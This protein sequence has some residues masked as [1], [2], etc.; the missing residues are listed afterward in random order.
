MNPAM[1]V[2]L[3]S[4]VG[5]ILVVGIVLYRYDLLGSKEKPIESPTA[6]MK[7]P[8]ESV[9]SAPET[10]PAAAPAESSVPPENLVL[11]KKLYEEKTCV[12]CHGADGKAQTPTGVAMKATDLSSGQFHNNKTNMESVAYIKQVIEAGVPGTAMVGFQ[13]QIPDEKDRSALA[14]YVHSLSKKK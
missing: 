10:K 12:L 5:A 4:V 6:A 14:Q 13:A 7:A 3:G 1:R 9:A 2:L 8:A 11:G